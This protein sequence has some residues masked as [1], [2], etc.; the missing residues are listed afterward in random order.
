[1]SLSR[2]CAKGRGG[3]LARSLLLFASTGFCAGHAFAQQ[4]YTTWRSYLGSDDSS[5]YSSLKQINAANLNELEVAWTYPTDDQVIY[6]FN[7]I[8]VDRVMYVMAKNFSVVALDATTGR[9]LWVHPTRPADAPM[10][11]SDGGWAW[12]HRGINYWQNKSGSDRRLIIPVNQHLEEIDAR[13]GKSIKS[14]GKDGLVDLRAGLG[15]NPESIGQIEF[16]TPGRIFENLLIVGS[17]TGED[18]WSPPGDI[19]AYDVRTGKM[20]WIFH[21]VPHPDEFGYNTWP[22]EAW[23]YAGGTNCWGE[24]SLDEKRGIVYI[25][26]GAPSYDF[27][28]ADRIG[29]NLFADT[30]L[31]LDA[32]TGKLIWHYQLIH[33]DLWD[34]DATAAPQLLTV[35]MDGKTIP[36]VAQASKQGFVYVFDRVTGK[37]LWPIEERP[38]P[39]SN[40]PGEVAS[41]TQPFPT[42]PP[43]FARQKFSVADLDRYILNP[44]ERASW[45]RRIATAVND[46]IFTPPELTDT[47]EMPGNLGG[48]NWGSTASDPANGTMYVVSMDIPAI[49]KN[50]SAPPSLLRSTDA[51]MHPGTKIPAGTLAEQGQI[52]YQQKCQLCHGV[53]RN[54]APPAIPSLVDASTRLGDSTI[55]SA[56]RNGAGD[57]PPFQDLND[58]GL[59]ALLAYLGNQSGGTMQPAFETGSGLPP[60]YPNGSGAP[61]ARY[62][63]G[64]GL[65]PTIIN[66]PWSTLTAYDMNKGEIKWQVPVGDAP[67]A[68]SEGIKDT[69]IMRPRGGAVVTGSGLLFYATRDEAK[70]RAYDAATGK[71]LWTV[72]LPAASNAVPAVYEED[73]R[74]Y[75]VVCA[76][77]PKWP[78]TKATH[79][80]YIAF[81]LP[82][83][84]H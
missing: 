39:K 35:Q 75:I 42:K 46:G 14:F 26:T 50:E 48:A 34:Y 49:L 38:V 77:A 17:A 11:T 73:G 62:W 79:R 15:R 43:P 57:M 66:P 84:R 63:S 55:R 10:I 1:M 44:D 65:E 9:E 40:M 76:A 20:V 74:E 82:K 59:N 22:K 36:I 80:G 61:T 2:R 81:A 4:A 72:D 19:R 16:D 29:N 25:P 67:Q 52:I 12:K 18:Y 30:L 47:I 45:T 37:P 23:K 64:Y 24:M 7:P 33:H 54:G 60:P 56:I 41:P 13:S 51:R 78:E 6:V 69:G 31:A 71:V 83:S 8:I 27:Y 3:R 53:D 70:L 21:T 32:R 5:H 28:G 68:A 58:A